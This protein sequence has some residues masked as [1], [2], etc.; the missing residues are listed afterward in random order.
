M[1]ASPRATVLFDGDCGV[2]QGLKQFA[3][4]HDTTG[5]LTFAPFQT[6][7]LDNLSPGLSRKMAGQA[8]YFI[9]ADGQRFRG[10]KAVFETMKRLPGLWSLVGAVLSLPLLSWLAEPFYRLFARRRARISQALSLD[11]C[12]TLDP[13]RVSKQTNLERKPR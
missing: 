6:A 1:T 11:R 7:D 9:R 4:S 5:R 3:E 8:L 13:K 2:C 10:A 12:Q